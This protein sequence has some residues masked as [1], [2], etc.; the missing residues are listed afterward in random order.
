[1]STS[2]NANLTT[3]PPIVAIPPDVKEEQTKFCSLHV[4]DRLHGIAVELGDGN[5][6]LGV[7]RAIEA[8]QGDAA[9]RAYLNDMAMRTEIY[10]ILHPSSHN[11]D[12]KCF[13]G[14]RLMEAYNTAIQAL[15]PVPQL[16]TP[17]LLSKAIDITPGIF[18]SSAPLIKEVETELLEAEANAKPYPVFSPTIRMEGLDLPDTFLTH[19]MAYAPDG[20]TTLKELLLEEA[21]YLTGKERN[22]RYRNGDSRYTILQNHGLYMPNHR[23]LYIGKSHPFPVSIME[24]LKGDLSLIVAWKTF[25]SVPGYISTEPTNY[26]PLKTRAVSI[27]LEYATFFN[28]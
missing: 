6:S 3:T 13:R 23:T 12:A 15:G 14:Q 8:A 16:P 17:V 28:I 21:A 10:S 24:A 1:M 11:L 9:R 2:I 7:R 18:Q 4:S 25:R 5:F 26:G 20:N 22:P 27:P 19:L